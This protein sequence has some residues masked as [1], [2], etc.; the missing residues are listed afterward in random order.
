MRFPLAIAALSLLASSLAAQPDYPMQRQTPGVIGQNITLAYTNAVGGSIILLIASTDN[1]PI[2]LSLFN[3]ADP[4]VLNVGIDLPQLWLTQA[5]GGGSGTF[6]YPTP[7]NAELHGLTLQ[8]QSCTLPGSP[9]LV[10]GISS[11]VAVQLG[12]SNRAA[13]LPTGLVVARGLSVGT[14]LDVGT[15][16]ILIAGGGSGTLLMPIGL[17][18]S[19]I[20]DAR[21]LTARAG[22]RLA[23]AR[24][25]AASAPIAGGRTLICGGVDS[26]GTVLNSA[27]IYDPATRTFTPTTSMATARVLHSAAMMPDGRVLVVGGTT[28]LSDA[29]QALANAQSSAEI[30]NPTT[31]TWSAAP[32]MA[33]RL[34]APGLHRVST[35]RVLVSGGFE[36]TV[37][38]G[39]P[40]PVGSVVS[41]QLFNP[42]TNTWGSAA[43][44]PSSRAVHQTTAAYLPNG[45]LVVTGGATSG[46]DL[47]MA[48]AIARADFYNAATNAWTALPDMAQARLGHSATLFGGRIVVAGGTQG[49]LAAPTPI[50]DVAALD[51]TTLTW[52]PLLPLNTVRGGHVAAVTA[53]GM[54]CLFG[55][56][57]AT[58]S[59]RT[60]ETIR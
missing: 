25:L 51:P 58:A 12:E 46:P 30:Y 1:G 20:F 14:A 2:P 24:A 9:F 47:T 48:A 54:L 7:N 41:C 13:T 37:F 3:I 31:G 28:I 22:P 32:S 36:V 27:E 59:L 29:L 19:E 11:L 23:S 45:H 55:G 17:D 49:S 15:Q 60:I 34:L 56:Q 44:M 21:S 39:I 4:R 5:V 52:S 40:I 57:D 10:G 6:S 35:G 38:F 33:R 26:I 53:D 50:A 16:E 8:F 18:S 42:T 43:S